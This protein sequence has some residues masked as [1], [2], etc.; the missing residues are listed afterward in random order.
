MFKEHIPICSIELLTTYCE[1]IYGSE[2]NKILPSN[3][4]YIGLRN[5]NKPYHVYILPGQDLNTLNF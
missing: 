1:N 3:Q 5:I 2:D 4:I